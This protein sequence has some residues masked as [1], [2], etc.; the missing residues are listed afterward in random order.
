M[1]V[2]FSLLLA[3]NSG[4]EPG[5]LQR[6]MMLGFEPARSYVMP[7]CTRDSVLG[8]R[9]NVEPASNDVRETANTSEM[10]V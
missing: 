4:C 2:N 5:D 10:Q 8:S 7:H 1:C 3:Q 9:R 6:L